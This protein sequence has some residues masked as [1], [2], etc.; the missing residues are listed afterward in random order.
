[1]TRLAA[2]LREQQADGARLDAVIEKNL[3]Q[4]GFGGRQT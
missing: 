1:M 4:P 3:E 2:R